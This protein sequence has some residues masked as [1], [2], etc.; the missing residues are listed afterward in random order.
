LVSEEDLRQMTLNAPTLQAAC[1]NMVAAANSAGGPDNIT[2]V[3]IQ[4][5]S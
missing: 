5:L 4:V 1:Q 3:L 2:A